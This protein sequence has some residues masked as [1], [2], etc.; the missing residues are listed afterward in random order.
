MPGRASH[1]PTSRERDILQRL[2]FEPAGLLI[3]SYQL[4]SQRMKKCSPKAGSS[5]R[6]RPYFIALR[7][8]VQRHLHHAANSRPVSPILHPA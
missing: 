3:T 2:L 1:L 8:Q 4:V 5:S 6:N 7:Q